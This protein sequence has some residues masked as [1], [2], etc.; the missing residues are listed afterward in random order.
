MY[1]DPRK[2][3]QRETVINECRRR[4]LKL[5]QTGL[6]WRITGVG[7]SLL[8]ADLANLDTQ[9]LTSYQPRK[10]DRA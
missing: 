2:Q 3:R 1:E 8:V 7:V 10:P 6:A 5:A 4:G 9:S